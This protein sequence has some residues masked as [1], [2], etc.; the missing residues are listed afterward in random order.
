MR[1]GTVLDV[2]EGQDWSRYTGVEGLGHNCDNIK[3]IKE[4]IKCRGGG[5]GAKYGG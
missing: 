3:A 1:Q 5:G 2:F 4:E